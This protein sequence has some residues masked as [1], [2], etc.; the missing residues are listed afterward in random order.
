MPTS[1]HWAALRSLVAGDGDSQLTAVDA[2]AVATA[3]APV[4]ESQLTV[5]A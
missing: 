4:H 5:E 3:P 1:A 2:N